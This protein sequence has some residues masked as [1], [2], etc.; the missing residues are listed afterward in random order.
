MGPAGKT[1]D[2]LE[3]EYTFLKEYM[4]LNRSIRSKIG[5]EFSSFIK[6]CTFRGKDCLNS[7]S[8][9]LLLLLLSSPFIS[10]L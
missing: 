7:R 10:F 6:S 1:P 4:T 5:H 8:P 2:Y 9:L 3:A